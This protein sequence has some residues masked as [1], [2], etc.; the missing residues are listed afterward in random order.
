[1]S[2]LCVPSLPALERPLR[3]LLAVALLC[4]VGASGSLA[5]T[6]NPAQPIT[7]EVRVQ[8]IHVRD[9]AGN[10]PAPLLGSASERASIEGFIDDIWAQAGIDIVLDALATTWNSTFGLMG[11]PGNNDPRPNSDL[12]AIANA[13]ALDGIL[14]ADPFTLHMFFVDI[15][16][17]FSQNG[18]N[19]VNGLAGLPGSISGVWVGPNLTTFGSGREVVASVLAHEIGHNLGL[20]HIVEAFNLMQSG[21]APNQGEVLNAS[22]VSTALASPFSVLV[23]EASSLLLLACA[24]A[25][26]VAR[27]Q[28]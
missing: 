5:L 24:L 14:A 25:M 11:N 13:A 15:V 18:N 1:M 20:P 6:I 19:T 2:S 4:L 17:G 22:Q 28:A 26:V 8:V 27:R 16:P 21:G 23:P 3:F 10:N 12:G 7:H 9:D